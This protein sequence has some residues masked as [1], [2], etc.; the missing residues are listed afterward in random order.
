[1]RML[2]FFTLL[3]ATTAV[4]ASGPLTTAD[5][6]RTINIVATDDMKYSVTTITASPGEQLRVRLVVKGVVPK[7]AM[8][9]NFVLLKP[10]TNINKLLADGAPHRDTDFVPPAM[11]SSVLAR[12]TLAGAGEMVQVTFTAP[13]KPGTYPY[14][15]TFGGHYQA[16]MKG[17]LV[18]K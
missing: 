4:S 15:C 11:M 7:V 3:L 5:P 10:R 12:T 6:P 14:I 16:G 13:A 9:H 2:G 8:S 18:V 1:M 17:V